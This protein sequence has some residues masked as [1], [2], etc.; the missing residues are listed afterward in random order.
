LSQ[1]WDHDEIQVDE[2]MQHAMCL[3]Q[4]FFIIMVQTSSVH[5][6]LK[7]EYGRKTKFTLVRPL[8]ERYLTLSLCDNSVR[9][10][11]WL[12]RDI[13]MYYIRPIITL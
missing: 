13:Y 10:I 7:G 8:A 6:R 4:S 11:L 9:V 3:N 5:S 2:W 12:K 1:I